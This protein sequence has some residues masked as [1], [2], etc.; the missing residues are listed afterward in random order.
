MT[1]GR[2]MNDVTE[3]SSLPPMTLREAREQAGLHVVALAAMLKV[4]V[5]K[6]EAL[7]SGRY[8]E[9]PDMTFA[10]GLAASVCR[11]LKVDAGP[12]LASLP[13]TA[14]VRLGHDE[15]DLNTPFPTE[16]QAFA[17]AVRGLFKPSSGSHLRPVLIALLLLGAAAGVWLGLP[18]IEGV[19]SVADNT[20]V[21]QPAQGNVAPAPV[22]N[23]AVVAAPVVEPVPVATVAVPAAVVL[24]APVADQSNQAAPAVQ[25]GA[26]MLQLRARQASWVQ[27]RGTNGKIL[28]E[29]NLP[30]GE[31]AEV[32]DEGPLAVVVGRAGD[33]DVIV[34]GHSMDI[35]SYSRNNVARFE[36]K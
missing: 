16:Q 1:V 4:S 12:V 15:G 3:P 33:V 23:P 8:D 36:V 14:E 28:L 6:L 10:R 29:R 22:E 11:V 18:A 25:G 20:E 17:G 32:V 21:V 26:P 5:Q 2:S 35:Q 13:Q 19:G 7:E 9:L 31:A 24:P 34:R 27:V 30:A